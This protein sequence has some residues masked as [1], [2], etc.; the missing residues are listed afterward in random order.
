MVRASQSILVLLQRWNEIVGMEATESL[1][2]QMVV[3]LAVVMFYDWEGLAESA[4]TVLAA[5]TPRITSLNP[6][7]RI[8]QSRRSSISAPLLNPFA[9]SNEERTAQLEQERRDSS[10]EEAR[11][12]SIRNSDDAK[13]AAVSFSNLEHG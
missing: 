6:A 5:P 10:L 8:S 1:P 12:V 3:M 7:P 13:R 9:L 11:R 2:L 4:V